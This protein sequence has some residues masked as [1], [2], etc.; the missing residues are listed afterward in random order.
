MLFIYGK[1]EKQ[2]S[3]KETKQNNSE[4]P[5]TRARNYWHMLGPGLTTGAA[6]DDPS[7]IV[8]YSQAGA[9]FN[10]NFLWTSVLTFPLMAVVQEMCARIGVVT[11]R[12]LAGSI[13]KHFSR[14]TLFIVAALLFV[15]NTFNIGA[16]L[17]M[18][19]E[20]VHMMLPV[21]HP[22]LFIIAISFITLAL[23]IFTS[24]KDYARYLK[25]LALIL[26]S[27]VLSTLSMHIEWNVVF[28]SLFVP[29]LA[30]TKSEVFVLAAIIGTTVSPYLFFWQTSQEVEEQ[31]LAGKTTIKQRE[32]ITTKE[33]IRTMRIDVWSGMFVS[34]LVM[35]FIIV[36][37]AATLFS[38]GATNISSAAQ[39]AEALRPLA[40][41]V[42]YILFALGVIGTGLLAVP[43]LAGSS[44]YAIAESFGWRE[45]L[46]RKFKQAHAFYAVI[47]VSVIFGLIIS[48]L[49][50]DPI[51]ILL[52]SA[53]INGIIAPVVLVLIVLLASNKKIMGEWVNKPT[54]NVIGWLSVVLMA[55]ISIAAIWSLF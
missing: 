31:I 14:R 29:Y 18:M 3:M 46:Y 45:G 28:H 8:T 35:F 23:Q 33:D 39:A 7:G 4:T 41:N 40:G 34:N 9:G 2:D 12:G 25:W 49:N 17:A 53:V 51:R 22:A 5:I 54:T 13:R 26:I 47:I 43:V 11:G 36:A 24:Y 20:V 27:Y 38:S 48:L 30:F 16:D 6:D 42:A 55:F 32:A 21:G 44:S 52:Y 37:S 19:G 1:I 10:F 15:A 50:F